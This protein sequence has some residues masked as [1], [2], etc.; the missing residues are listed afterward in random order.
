MALQI[1]EMTILQAVE[2]AVAERAHG[3]LGMRI[4]VGRKLEVSG[5]R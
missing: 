3:P 4:D 1:G 2:D 5:W